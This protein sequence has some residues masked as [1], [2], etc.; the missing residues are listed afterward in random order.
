V[1]ARVASINVPL[2]W[3]ATFIANVGYIWVRVVPYQGYMGY[4]QGSEL[5]RHGG[6]KKRVF[7]LW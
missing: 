4:P 2:K 3:G 5:L 1:R 6:A 7:I